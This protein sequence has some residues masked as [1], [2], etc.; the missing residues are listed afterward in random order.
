MAGVT[1]SSTVAAISVS[2]APPHSSLAPL[3][4]ASSIKTLQCATVDMPTTLPS[5]T[6]IGPR[7]SPSDS[8]LTLAMNLSRRR[9]HGAQ[10]SGLRSR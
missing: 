9:V 6:R 7:G 2:M 10:G 4:S 3:A 1:W 8:A 5:T